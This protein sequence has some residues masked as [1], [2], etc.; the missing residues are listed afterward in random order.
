[1]SSVDGDP[2]WTEVPLLD[3]SIVPD[4]ADI[5]V[6]L[7]ACADRDAWLRANLSSIAQVDVTTTTTLV[8]PVGTTHAI[9]EAC[10]GGGGGGKGKPRSTVSN[11]NSGGGG[12]GGA[13]RRTVVVPAAAGESFTAT[14]GAGGAGATST[15]GGIGGDSFFTRVTGDQELARFRGAGAGH[16]GVDGVSFVSFNGVTDTPNYAFAFGGQPANN[17]ATIDNTKVAGLSMYLHM[18]R[19]T[20][21]QAGGLGMSSNVGASAPAFAA[22]NMS[23]EAKAGGLGGTPG[24]TT[25]ISYHGGGCGGGGGGGPY[26]IGGDGGNGTAVNESGVSSSGTAGGN[27]PDN[28]GAGGGGGGSAGGASS[29]G[30]LGG[31]GGNGGSGFMRITWIRRGGV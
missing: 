8:A 19:S 4:G 26:G 5:S 17:T 18:Y 24:T 22:G 14:I 15:N 9:I 3:D 20:T 31:N 7:E 29:A 28:S 6:P 21:P 2:I 1:M 30:G 11:V 16:A 27:A 12:G 13:V 10:G 23:P 25:G